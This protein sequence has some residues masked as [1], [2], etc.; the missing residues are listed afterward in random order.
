MAFILSVNVAE[1]RKNNG[2][3]KVSSRIY[4]DYF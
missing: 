1:I 4:I 2:L 3:D